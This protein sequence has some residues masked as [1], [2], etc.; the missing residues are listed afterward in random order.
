MIQIRLDRLGV[1]GW[2]RKPRTLWFHRPPCA[3]SDRVVYLLAEEHA[4]CRRILR[5]T[6]VTQTDTD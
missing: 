1:P 4:L 6:E 3:K 2:D 5:I